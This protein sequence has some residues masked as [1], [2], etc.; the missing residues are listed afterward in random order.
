MDRYLP[1]AGAAL[2]LIFATPA[3][4][5]QEFTATLAGHAVLPA[6]SFIE[7]PADAPADMKVSAKYTTGVRVEAVGTVMGRSG[8]RPTGVSAPFRGQPQQGHSGIKSMP[9]G[10]FWVI[11]DNGMGAKNNSMDSMLYLNRYR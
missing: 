10:T 3:F 8:D 1:S 7:A 4:A 6:Q 9:D 11:T 5:Q 2:A